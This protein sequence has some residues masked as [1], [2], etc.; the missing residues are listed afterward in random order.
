VVIMPIKETIK[1]ISKTAKLIQKKI[2]SIE[3]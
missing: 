3:Y 2:S 1:K